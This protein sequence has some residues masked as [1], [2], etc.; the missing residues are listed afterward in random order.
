MEIVKYLYYT[1]IGCL[2]RVQIDFGANFNH[3]RLI[4]LARR[5][6]I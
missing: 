3:D 5:N 6:Y 4:Y 1:V 2:I